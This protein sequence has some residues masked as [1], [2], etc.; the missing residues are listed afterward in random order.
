M[1]HM[2]T[3]FIR[4]IAFV[5]AALSFSDLAHAQATYTPLDPARIY[6]APEPIGPSSRR[7]GLVISEIMYNPTNRADARELEFIELYNSNPW[8]ENIGGYRLSGEVDYILPA[9]TSI[10]PLSYL[11]I[12]PVPADV[13]TVYGITGVLGGF[14]NRLN[15]GSGT[16]R[17]RDRADSV[18]VEVNY[19]DEPPFPPSADGAGHSLVLARP[20]YGEGNPMAW[21]ASDIVGGSPRAGEFTRANTFRT[22]VINEFMAHTDEPQVDFIE[23]FN[24]SAAP[25]NISGCILA[26]DAETNKFVI[27]ANTTIP[28]RGFVSFTQTQ[29]GFALSSDG[30]TIYF[31]NPS[32]NKV[33]DAVRFEAQANGIST[34][35]YPDGA[36][37]F[38]ELTAPTPGAANNNLL[39]R[40]VVIN[41]IHYNPI[42]GNNDDEFIELYNR[43]TSA[44]NIGGWRLTDGVDFS[45][46]SNTMILPNSYVV[47]ANDR[48]RLLSVYTGL[49]Q[50]AVFGNYGGSLGNGGE[51]VALTMPDQVVATNQFGV[52]E[53]NTIRIVV[54]EVTYGTG[55]RWGRFHDGNGASL[56]LTDAR[57]DNRLA[58]NWADSDDSTKARWTTIELTGILDHGLMASADQLQLFLLGEGECLVDNVEVIPQGGGNLVPNST[59]DAGISGWFVQGTHEDSVWQSTGGFSG[60]CL[61]V[62]ASG[63]GDTGAN[64]IRAPLT[65][66][67][68]G[69]TTVTLRARVQWLK[70]HPEILLRLHGNWLEAT[71]N[72][73]TTTAFGTPGARNSRQVANAG[74]AITDVSHSP[75]QPAASQ[76]V[77]VSAQVYDPDA[78]SSVVLNYRVDPATAFTSVPMTYNGA[79]YYSAVVPGQA[80]NTR[81]AFYIEATDNNA[82]RVASRFPND[83]PVREC[84]IGFGEPFQSGSFGAYRFWLSQQTLNRWNTR[85]KNNNRPL[86]ATFVHGTSRVMYNMQT[87][88]SGSPFVS[89][90]YSGP[91]GG[92][93][94]YVLRFHDDDLFLGNDDFVLDWPIRD[95]SQQAEQAAYWIGKEIGAVHLYRRFIHLYINGNRRGAIYED[96]QQPGSDMIEQYYPDDTD[97]TLHKIEDW[98][99]FGDS[100]DDRLGNI[101]ATLG[102]FITSGGV[103]KTARYRWCWR[104]RAVQESANNFTNLFAL[105]DAVNT[106]SGYEPF[107]TRVGSLVD[108]E[109][110]MRAL[111]YE[112]I[113]GNWDS[114][115]YSRGK[116][117]Y[118]Y[119]PQGSGWVLMP[120]DIDFVFNYGADAPTTGLF[121]GNE[122]FVNRMKD[123]PAFQRVYWRALEDAVNGP[124]LSANLTPIL[125]AKYNALVANGVAA[126]G[127]AGIQ[128]YVDQRRNYILS[129]LATVA[130]NFVVSGPTAFS[131]NRNL[132]TISGTAPVGVKTITI[133]G[134]AYEPVWTSVTA[135]TIRV[136]LNA[137]A[138]TLV[139]RGLNG[140]GVPVAG[141]TA[142]LNITY[143]GVNELPQDRLVI[144]EVMYNPAVPQGAFVEI[145]N[146]ST[147]NAFDLSRWRISGVDCDIPDGTIIEPGAYLVF[148]QNREVFASTYGSSLIVSG[149]FDG[150]LDNGG[151]TIKLIRPGATPAE[152]LIVDQVTYDDDAP[153]PVEADG[154]GPSL[155]LIDAA[156]DNNRVAN[157]GVSFDPGVTNPPI[158]LFPMTGTWRYQTNNMDGQNWTARN[159]NDTAWPSGPALLYVEPSALPEP[160][161]TPLALKATAYYFRSYFNYTGSV[162]NVSLAFTAL[163]DDGAVFYLNGAELGRVGMDPGPVSYAT[164]ATR[165]VDNAVNYDNLL[166]AAT[167]LVQGSNCVAV[168]VHQIN[169]GSSDIVFGSAIS[170]A[171]SG[172]SSMYTPARAN[173]IVGTVP[174]FPRL[175]LNEVLP[176]NVVGVTDRFGDRDPWVEIHNGGNT[177]ASL[178]GFYLA[179]Q[180]TNLTQWA[181][182]AATS[183]NPGQFLVVWLD[184]EPGESISSELHTSFRINSTTG[185]VALVQMSGGMPRVV[186][187]INYNVASAGRSYGDYPDGNVS[188][189]KTFSIITPGATNNPA[190]A[191][192]DVFI[193]EWMA[194][195]TTTLPDPADGDYED[196]IELYNPSSEVVDLSGYFMTDVLTNTTMWEFPEGTT[197]P[198]NGFLLVWADSE[199]SQNAPGGEP[200]TN[201]R[202]G[203]AGEAIGLYGAGGVLID[204]VTFGAQTNGIA[205][206]RFRDGQS[207]I[208]YMT[209]TPRAPNFVPATSNSAPTIAVITPKTAS[210]GSLLT[211]TVDGDDSDAGQTL[212]YQLEPGAPAGAFIGG[213][214]GVFSWIPTE[215]QGPNNY[216]ITVRVTDNGSP[217]LSATRLFTV[218]VNEVN[219]APVLSGYTNRTVGEGALMTATGSVTDS[220]T[221]PQAL[222]FSLDATPPAGATI[223]PTTGVVS[224]TPSEAQGPGTHFITVRVTDNG[225]PALSATTTMTVIVSEVNTAPVLASIGNYTNGPGS[226]IAFTASATDA[227]EPAQTLTYSLDADAPAG[228]AIDNAGAFT[229]TPSSAQAGT[230]NVITVRATDD[231][232][233]PLSHTRSFTVVVTRELKV[234]DISIASDTVT[235]TWDS[236][237]GRSYRLQRKSNLEDAWSNVGGLINASGSTA[238]TTDT[239]GANTRQFY[240]VLQM[241]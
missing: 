41:E 144:N 3:K 170:T 65:S 16:V 239:V 11:L 158:A 190:G 236:T 62:V 27:P 199:N 112:R 44:V 153:W 180:Y 60:G 147:A 25:V 208:Y 38:H 109:R 88:Y 209:P 131:T 106:P 95:G 216:N 194:D 2:L 135:W 150:S 96:T 61:R 130:A 167:N 176:N 35:R 222:T 126:E 68:A 211:F 188:G 70:G 156:Q 237:P 202:L 37:S 89:P 143:T 220:D 66:I 6:G 233:P 146:R 141:G 238:S 40:P 82:T 175:W 20:S 71:G 10:G 47:V 215:A 122:P 45:F 200:H 63:R 197:I 127:I 75:I 26:D 139:V 23:L 152:D 53:T 163:I 99:E 207:A 172:S 9:N 33:L 140:Q 90:G 229:W 18:L 100:G 31:K 73:L 36:P 113:S 195:N 171:P 79:G 142:T 168:E 107:N 166:F 13:Q 101:D 46:P 29:L 74:P 124:M 129:Q 119:K 56:E 219:N 225:E 164:F 173:S 57:A 187:H 218:Q 228:A 59:F 7:S 133:N 235:I 84:L 54:D 83:A 159:Y 50:A 104:P 241:N 108:M 117:M 39:L 213:A 21:M 182:P 30:E 69:G 93:C 178:S 174:A 116:N 42:T 205:H 193:N 78:L 210:E 179:G 97:G 64:R 110:W 185:S 121:G 102:N 123:H 17:L 189:R 232:S 8:A 137:G 86:D 192:V 72:F 24:Y 128:T 52:L 114:Y 223:H 145:H 92:L 55:G 87:L 181:F 43:G 221:P 91:L 138:N 154:T 177:A 160:K 49:P 4:A 184:G 80:A 212:T 148:A 111:A 32:N 230:T 120:W 155:Q 151:E 67:P 5:V 134:I 149:T 48:V 203:A 12:A 196:W 81:V 169:A 132:I 227:D 162:A 15:N 14:T 217:N 136:A 165:L 22:V 103:K 204:S 98:F 34:G 118:A 76:A 201:F 58:P 1:T 157:W 224:W 191:V 183:I 85:T 198:A 214:N 186:D 51:R 105:V 115:G 234:S 19:S 240:R 231:G 28:A 77:V 206:G 125:T 161:N 226:T 94:G